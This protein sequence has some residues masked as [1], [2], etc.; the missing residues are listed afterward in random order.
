M[1][2]RATIKQDYLGQH[3]YIDRSIDRQVS[4]DLTKHLH[5]ELDKELGDKIFEYMKQH[6]REKF[7]LNIDTGE[8]Y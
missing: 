6:R 3:E 2:K 5:E 1:I 8:D 7:I 4:E